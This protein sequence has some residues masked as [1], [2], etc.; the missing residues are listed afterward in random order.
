MRATIKRN[1]KI[2]IGKNIIKNNSAAATVERN[3]RNG[4]P[5]NNG[6]LNIVRVNSS[7]A[8]EFSTIGIALISIMG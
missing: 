3:I 4:C 8:F 7:Q 6:T 1:T 2:L 5:T